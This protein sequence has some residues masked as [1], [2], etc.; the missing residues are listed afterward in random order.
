[1]NWKKSVLVAA[2]FAVCIGAGTNEGNSGAGRTSIDQF[3]ST[4]A[5]GVWDTYTTWERWNGSA[6][7]ATTAATQF[8]QTEDKATVLVGDTV[9]LD[10]DEAVGYLV[11]EATGSGVGTVKTEGN[12]LTI[13]GIYGT[14]ALDIQVSGSNEALLEISKD[15]SDNPGVVRLASSDTHVVDGEIRLPVKESRLE[16]A[17]ALTLEGSG[18]VVGQ[19]DACKLVISDGKTFTSEVLIEGKM[20]LGPSASGSAIFENEGIIHANSDGVLMIE[21]GI[22]LSAVAA[23]LQVEWDASGNSAATLT[24]EGAQSD[25]IARGDFAVADCAL[26]QLLEVV[27]TTGSFTCNSD[28]GGRVSGILTYR[29]GTLLEGNA[30]GC[31]SCPGG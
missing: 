12:T 7:V 5:G 24:F 10:S 20:K 11:I 2:S 13:S 15:A 6:W 29:C 19:D 21:S 17:E 30:T 3:Q 25:C 31:G 22:T 26:I 4:G 28:P 8:P 1:M 14:Q 23:D 16:I 27:K 9:T 18:H